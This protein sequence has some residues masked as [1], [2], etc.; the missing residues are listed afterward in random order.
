MRVFGRDRERRIAFASRASEDLDLSVAA[1]GT[2]REAV[3]EADI[4]VLATNS[5][6][7][8]ID[9]AWVKDGAFVTT[10]GPKL[11]S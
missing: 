11:V 7:P 2:A 9:A 5:P 3:E 10:L 6:A 8:V 4:V 1:V